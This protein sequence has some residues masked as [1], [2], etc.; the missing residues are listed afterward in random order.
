MLAC[1]SLKLGGHPRRWELVER[2]EEPVFHCKDP[3]D[4]LVFSVLRDL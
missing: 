3:R 4:R 1:C 2:E